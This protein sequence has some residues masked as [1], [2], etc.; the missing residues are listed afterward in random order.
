LNK[1]SNTNITI[2]YG[3]G[4]EGS[5]GLFFGTGEVF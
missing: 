1:H 5:K 4:A 3:F 2:D